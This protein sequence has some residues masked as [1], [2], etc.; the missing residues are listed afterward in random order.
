MCGIVG[1]IN[2][3][4]GVDRVNFMTMRDSLSHRGPDDAGSEYFEQD[5]IALGH[6]RLSFLDLSESGRQPMCNEDERVWI[7]FNG[8]IYNYLE[9]RQE[10][11]E[12]G[13]RFKTHS[14][15]EVI[16]HGYE[17]WDKEV[18]T[19]LKG[20]F[21]IGLLDLNQ[22]KLLLIR[23]RFGI[24]PLY[25]THTKSSLVFGSELKAIVT[26]DAVQRDVDMSAVADYLVYR[27]VPSPKTIW[28]GIA[29]LPPAHMLTLDYR[30]FEA[31]IEEYW[32]VP[33]A[34]PWR[35]RGRADDLVTR[36]GDILAESVRIHARSDVPVGSFLS[37]GYDSSAVV[38]YLRKAGY[39][40]DTF[41]IGFQ[42]WD[43]S[44]HNYADMVARS[45][46]TP[47]HYFLAND[48]T[49]D[50]LDIMPTVYDE[51]IAD[52]SILPTWLVSR[53][54]AT[55][56][57]AVM[58]GEGADELFGGYWWQKKI[59]AEHPG[60]SSLLE[61]IKRMFAPG[62]QR[63]DVVEFYADANAM[64]RFDRSELEKAFSKDLH[65]HLPADPDWFYRKHYDARLS[66]MKA[67]QRM[68]IK[69]F[70]GELILVKV[71]R[72]SM[73]HSL[74][75]RVPF[76]DHELFE[77]VLG[78]REDVYYRPDVTKYLLN[79]QIKDHL[80]VEIMNRPKQGFVGPDDFYKNFERYR[81]ELK[82]SIL[83]DRHI[84]NS[85]YVESLF[86]TEDAWRVW[87]IVVLENWFKRWVG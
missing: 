47:F 87:K 14:D 3:N 66:P 33:I 18:V 20:M 67:V 50:L 52:I 83:L 55:K 8:E 70:M 54:A 23:D 12:C 62:D 73:A 17:E 76:L 49:L 29:K 44:E 4:S 40:P 2:R 41:A 10:L 84:L 38:Y 19:R 34:D 57:K 15:T 64:G 16:L 68:D 53:E 85:D 9:L 65:Q 58:S 51:P 77:L 6:R 35:G 48:E 60:P 27:Y 36:T 56:V 71:D 74:E 11:E 22:Q 78:Y 42:G 5:R 24:K 37:G 31:Q 79:E 81:K 7:V 75:V 80:P 1:W 39:R 13:H 86:A 61:R 25:Y 45:L 26:C 30:T 72:A 43:N 28:Q 21:A 82:E 59:C 32:Q 69:C 63:P 46:D